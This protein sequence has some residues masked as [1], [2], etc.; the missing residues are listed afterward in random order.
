MLDSFFFTHVCDTNNKNDEYYN[1]TK[2]I[3]DK[4]DQILKTFLFCGNTIDRSKR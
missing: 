1:D 4:E 3:Q 2:E